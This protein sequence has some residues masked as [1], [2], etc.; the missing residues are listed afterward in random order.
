MSLLPDANK[1]IRFFLPEP[2]LAT[3]K[4]GDR[5][6]V[7]CD[8][9]GAGLEAEITFIASQAEFTPPVIYSKD[10]REKLVFRVDARPL[11]DAAALKVGQP[12]DITLTASGAGS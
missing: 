9:C 1:K 4:V 3:I 5:V 2:L 12:L 8:N 7:G 6:R 10:N 11:G